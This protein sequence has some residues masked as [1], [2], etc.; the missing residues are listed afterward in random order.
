MSEPVLGLLVRLLERCL[1]A[2]RSGLKRADGIAKLGQLWR[3]D[4][5]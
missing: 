2:R 1:L 3:G 5:L 4:W